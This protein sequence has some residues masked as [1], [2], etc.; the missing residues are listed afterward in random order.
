MSALQDAALCGFSTNCV[1]MY[2]HS[3][4][5]TQFIAHVR[6]KPFVIR[7]AVNQQLREPSGLCISGKP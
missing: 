6:M 3:L 7:L 1:S 4:K 2:T 5:S